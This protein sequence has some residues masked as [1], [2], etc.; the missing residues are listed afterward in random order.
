M[1]SAANGM[2]C[3]HMCQGL[4]TVEIEAW[5][6]VLDTRQRFV[7]REHVGDDLCASHR[8]VIAAQT[9][10]GRRIDLSAAADS[11]D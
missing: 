8:E 7:D 9:A 5:G 2:G 4:L 3:A 6:G 1:V 11:R 10:N